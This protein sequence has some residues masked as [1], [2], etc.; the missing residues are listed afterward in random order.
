MKIWATDTD[1]AYCLLPYYTMMVW[2][3]RPGKTTGRW[4]R[5]VCCFLGLSLAYLYVCMYVVHLIN[6]CCCMRPLASATLFLSAPLL[7][8]TSGKKVANETNTNETLLT[9]LRLPAATGILH[10]H[11]CKPSWP[12]WWVGRSE[13]QQGR[14][15]HLGAGKNTSSSQS[16]G[17]RH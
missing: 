4:G 11:T 5:G 6:T 16:A 8:N 10:R 3:R 13:A 9:H 15:A 12:W 14:C 2:S 1:T 17:P 7:C